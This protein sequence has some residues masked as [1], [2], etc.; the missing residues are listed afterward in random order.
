MHA[1]SPAPRATRPLAE[2]PAPSG[3][4]A[5]PDSALPTPASAEAPSEEGEPPD[6]LAAS[7]ADVAEAKRAARRFLAGYLPYSYGRRSARDIAGAT[8]QLRAELI[9]ERPRAPAGERNRRPRI[10][11][12]Q[13]EGAGRELAAILALVNDGERR[14]T[15]PLELARLQAGWRVTDVGS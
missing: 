4:A 15:V 1:T 3:T 11:L 10:V 2:P 9:S 7:R 6:A 12:L 14:Y 13:T 5:P 8:P